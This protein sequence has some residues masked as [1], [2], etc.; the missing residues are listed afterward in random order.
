LLSIHLDRESVDAPDYVSKIAKI[1]HLFSQGDKVV[2]N[3]FAKPT[4]IQ[5]MLRV[6]PS[7]PQDVLILLL[8]SIRNIS[9]DSTTLDLL[10]SA[11]AIPALIPFL[12]A[13]QVSEN[14]H[15]VLLTMYYLCQIKSSRQET[16]ALSGIIPHLQRF[17][18]L[19]HPLKQFAYPIIF[20]L[21]KTSS[22]TRMELKKNN[23]VQ[24]YIDILTNGKDVYWRNH[25]LEVLSFWMASSSDDTARVSLLLNTPSNLNK[26]IRVFR[27]STDPQMFEKMLPSFRKILAV[28]VKVNQ[29]LG[30]TKEFT[31]EIRNRLGATSSSAGTRVELL[32]MLSLLFA[33]HPNPSQLAA[34]AD[35][36][37][38]LQRLMEDKSAVLVLPLAHK[39]LTQYLGVKTEGDESVLTREPAMSV[40]Y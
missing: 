25:A 23:G 8:K 28:S 32:K 33:A 20:L 21:A 6:L 36:L 5:N 34:D 37:P 10:E 9:M 17:I 24:F 12:E 1:L 15:Q 27:E 26:L 31:R 22:K 7:V 4:V 30:R 35:L 3:H 14:Q 13:T 2:K 16:A 38:V 40:V 19:D 29:S 11:G 39:L 18:R